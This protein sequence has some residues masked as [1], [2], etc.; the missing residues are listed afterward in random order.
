MKYTLVPALMAGLLSTF[1]ASSHAASYE[2]LLS[3]DGIKGTSTQKGYSAFIPIDTWSWSITSPTDA[4][5]G[6]PTGKAKTSPFDWTQSVDA[7]VP[8]EFLDVAKN[9]NVKTVTL[10][11]IKPSSGRAMSTVIFQIT[12]SNVRLTSLTF[13][14]KD[15]GSGADA[16]LSLVAQKVTLTYSPKSGDSSQAVWDVAENTLSGSP[17]A[18]EGLTLQSSVPEPQS[19]ALSLAGLTLVGGAAMR[20]RQGSR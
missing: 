2:Y 14:G 5:T 13:D 18:F 20:R 6:K 3:I 15:A 11:V 9:T 4:A 12:F 19:L 1:A 7:S 16:S 8:Q 17:F 10:D